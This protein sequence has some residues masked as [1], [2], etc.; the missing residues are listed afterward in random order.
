MMPTRLS[1]GDRL[2]PY[3]VLGALGAGGMGEVYRARDTRLREAQVLA[4]L[5]DAGIA[6]IFGLEESGDTKALVLELVEGPTLAER[7]AQGPLPLEEALEIAAAIATALDAAH[8]NGIVHRDLK[9][10]N[11][12]IR[13]DGVVKVLDFGL[14]KALDASSGF[15]MD[16]AQSPTLTAQATRS[17]IIL[18]TAAY[19][20]PEQ[21]K[22]KAV[23]R[24]AD[25]WAFGVVLFEML[26]G[27]RLFDGETPSEVLAAVIL[28]EP[29]LSP[30]PDET[31]PHVRHLLARCLE[32]DPRLRLRDIGEARLALRSPA[33]LI[34]SGVHA[35]PGTFETRVHPQRAAGRGVLT[36]VLAGVC[37]ALAGAAVS[38][39]LWLLRPAPREVMRFD[40]LLPKDAALNLVIRPAV[41]LSA[42]GKSLAYIASAEGVSRLYVRRRDQSEAHVVPGSEGAANP[43]F[44]PDGR[45]IAFGS[46]NQL[47]KSS[48]E[49]SAIGL[50]PMIDGRGIAWIDSGSILYAPEPVGGLFR[51]DTNGGTPVPVT[52]LDDAA[53]ERT[54]RWPEVLP[55]GRTALFTVGTFANPDSY[56]ASN[57]D[58]VDLATGRR[59]AVLRGSA[60]ARFVPP[61][62]LVYARG[63]A[64]Y[65]I[66]F[67]PKTL[68]TA[69]TAVALMQGVDEDT[70][71]GGT[72][73]SCGGDG[74]LAYISGNSQT[75]RILSWVDRDGR[76]EPLHLPPGLYNDV[77]L[78]PDGLRLAVAVG[79]TGSADI[80]VYDFAR[81]TFTRLTFTNVNGT[82]LWSADGRSIL[83]AAIGEKG[84]VTRVLRVPADGGRPPE[85][86]AALPARS[87]LG[88]LTPDG[89]A[90]IAVYTNSQA[91]KADVVRLPLE[92]GSKPVTLAGTA[93]DEYNPS[94][95]PDG[96]YIAYQSNDAGRDDVYVR[97]A[98][99]SGDR[100]Q[101]SSSG[102]EEPRWSADG[103][104]LTYR[105]ESRLMAVPVQTKGTF[106]MG[107]PHL[108][109]NGIFPM[110]SDT[111]ISYDTDGAHRRFLMI[112]LASSDDAA[113]ALH[114]VLNWRDEVER[115]LSRP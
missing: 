90:V 41:S 86:V 12:K 70:T 4:S 30:L 48:I 59:Q 102:G 25:I 3:E 40:I 49:G 47:R 13:P 88:A 42:D 114:V 57:I 68:R 34:A 46:D 58:A 18:G 83:Y 17:G 60:M 36:W 115:L 63:G 23:D 44:S 26:A 16:V 93:S 5:N 94:I 52:H 51:I 89:K 7:I 104:E 65:G 61:G 64:L 35:A 22:G 8:E 2:G 50:A 10:A 99:G 27:R 100:W 31:P 24:R 97:D 98:Q 32:R 84:D 101:V 82:P 74:S 56:D 87:Y 80:W 109:F 103:T 33:S 53:R 79:S 20:A 62:T 91:W 85:E 108:L 21:A 111:G 15:G 69:G 95:S 66:R 107:V 1:P 73:F 14:A 37:A 28:K 78:S 77:R 106:T 29:D 54:H 9:P 11:V 19:M 81:T 67:D 45:W 96:R 72:H 113:S 55:G 76:V 92:K 71:T 75:G 110:R 112:R 43:V 39:V 105:V 6:A 38:V